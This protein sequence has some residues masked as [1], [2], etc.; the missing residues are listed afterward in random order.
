VLHRLILEQTTAAFAND[1]RVMN[2]DVRAAVLLDE[3]PALLVVEPL[4]FTHGHVS[5]TSENLTRAVAKRL[6][7]RPSFRGVRVASSGALGGG[8]RPFLARGG[9]TASSVPC[10]AAVRMSGRNVDGL[11]PP[12]QAGAGG[13]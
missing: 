5:S 10:V 12:G 3:A 7:T 4:H 13:F 11:I 1:L 9:P 8:A 6:R 2:E